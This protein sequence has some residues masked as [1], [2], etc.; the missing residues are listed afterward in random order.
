M[1]PV[2]HLT[3]TL[4]AGR[5]LKLSPALLALGV[6]LPDLV[7][8]SLVIFFGIGGGRFVAHT[9]TFAGIA[10]LAAALLHS[11]RAGAS[12]AFGIAAHLIED[13]YSF[14]P[15]FYPLLD[16]EFPVVEGYSIFDHYLGFFG[17]GTDAM[18]VLLFIAVRW[19]APALL[20]SEHLRRLSFRKL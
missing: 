4:L 2:A 3:F 11:R 1:Y 12:L 18:G 14:V 15:W 5:K 10:G 20:G 16:Y 17:I 7:D 13:A 9:L 8:K 6:L 19:H